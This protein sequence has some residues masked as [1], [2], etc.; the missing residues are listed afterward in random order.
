MNKIKTRS[1][2]SYSLKRKLIISFSLMSILPLL[3]CMYLVSNYILPK[4][5]LKTDIAASILISIFIAAIGFFVVKEIFDRIISVTT[6]AKLIAAGDISRK[7]EIAYPDEVG[8]LS[9]ALNQLTQRIRTNMDEL[10]NY[11]E[12]TTE[13]NL[14]IQKRI[15]VLSSLLQI[16]SLITQG[17]KLEDILKVAV[18]RSRFL[19]NSD[20]SYLLFRKEGEEAFSMK[21]ADGINS[22]YLLK[23]NVGPKDDLFSRI[24]KTNKPLILDKQNVLPE[25]LALSF[26]ERFR[27]KNTLALPVYLRGR[28]MAI[29]GIGNTKEIFLYR[30]DDLEL[31][32]IF[33]KQIA[34]AVENDILMQR[35]EKLEIKDALTGLYNAA[36]MQNRLQEE[37]KRAII[38]R[39]P[40]AFLLFNIDNFKRFHENFGLL[41]SEAALKKIAALVRDS[42][43]EID[44]AGRIGDNEFA[45]ILPEKNKRQAG[46]VAEDIRK[47]IEVGLSQ[48]EDANKRI[49]VSGGVSENPLDGVSSEELISKAKELVSLAKEKGRN[50]IVSFKEA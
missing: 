46:K 22:E 32:D 16:S 1:L 47:K 3:V 18:E 14:E 6:E 20:V 43:S 45:V 8:D 37:I 38:Y 50:C 41:Q 19:A 44:R 11:S 25:N 5:G 9:D 39:R 35:V 17:A 2:A 24:I 12:K 48:E 23:I 7:L 13:I 33:A 30:K 4:I 21:I 29:L 36:F 10:K 49:T 31:L 40:C 28:V 26:Y 27:L 42:V 15:M 34:I